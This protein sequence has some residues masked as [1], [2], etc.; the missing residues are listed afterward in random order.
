MVSKSKA[1]REAATKAARVVE[2]KKAEAKAARVVEAKSKVTREVGADKQE[3][4]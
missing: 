3:E 1:A 2:V 4:S